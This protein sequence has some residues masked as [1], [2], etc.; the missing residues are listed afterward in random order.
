[1]ASWARLPLLTSKVQSLLALACG[2]Q[3]RLARQPFIK[4]EEATEERKNAHGKSKQKAE[5]SFGS[6]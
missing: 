5:F 4:Q 3:C 2:Y 6:N 1:M